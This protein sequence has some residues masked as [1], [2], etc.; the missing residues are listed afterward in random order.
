[1]NK[2]TLKYFKTYYLTNMANDDQNNGNNKDDFQRGLLLETKPKT[3][4]I[5]IYFRNLLKK[6]DLLLSRSL[7]VCS[8]F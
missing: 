7:F 2:N 5:L 8:F 4:K 3:K 1:M 6:K